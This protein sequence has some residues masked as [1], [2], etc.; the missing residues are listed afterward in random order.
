MCVMWVIVHIFQDMNQ[1]IVL[2]NTSYVRGCEVKHSDLEN[3]RIKVTCVLCI[4]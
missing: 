2:L 3:V 4:I 1:P